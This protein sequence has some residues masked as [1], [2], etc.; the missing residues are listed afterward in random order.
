MPF[1]KP[2]AETDKFA[3]AVLL[4]AS[5]LLLFTTEFKVK[6]QVRLVSCESFAVHTK[7]MFVTL[8]LA[9]VSGVLKVISG[10]CIVYMQYKRLV[11]DKIATQVRGI[12]INSVFAICKIIC[13]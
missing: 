13:V 3:T 10:G 9:K 11:L 7:L 4:E 6:L 12:N 8:V 1:D 2:A 5:K